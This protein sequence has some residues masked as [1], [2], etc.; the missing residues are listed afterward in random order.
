[1]QSASTSSGEVERGN[2]NE[3]LDDFSSR[4]EGRPTRLEL[5]DPELGSQ[6][7]EIH[8]PLVGI[9]FEPEGSEAGSVEIILGG[10]SADDPRHMEHI[11]E[12]AKRFV[13]IPGTHG[14]EAGI[15]V[16]S[17]DGSRTLLTFEDLPE[18]PPSE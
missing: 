16:E 1:M 9:S 7:L 14:V 17:G 15:A 11:V 4:N 6:E 5:I 12:D 10:K 2:W 18:L 13:P 3:Y 8:L